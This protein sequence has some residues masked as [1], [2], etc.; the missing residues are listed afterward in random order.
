MG[1]IY[2]YL[3]SAIIG[4]TV[5]LIIFGKNPSDKQFTS[6]SVVVCIVAIVSS[7]VLD[8]FLNSTPEERRRTYLEKA[9][10]NDPVMQALKDYDPQKYDLIQK[11]HLQEHANE[12]ERAEKITAIVKGSMMQKLPHTSNETILKFVEYTSTTNCAEG[13]TPAEVNKNIILKNKDIV[14]QVLKTYDVNRPIPTDNDMVPLFTP[15]TDRLTDMHGSAPKSSSHETQ[16]KW[17]CAISND[18]MGEILNHKRGADLARWIMSK[19]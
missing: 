1:D 9:F 6:F 10:S 11:V 15:I 18:M 2:L 13:L 16:R 5:G 7:S 4:V 14:I 17:G 3:I 19:K 8:T 12:E